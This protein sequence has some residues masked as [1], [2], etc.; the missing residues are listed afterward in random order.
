MR[1]VSAPE[2]AYLQSRQ[3]YLAHLLVHVTA[4]NLTSGLSESLGIWTGEQDRSFVI[5]GQTLAYLAAPGLPPPDPVVYET[6]L[7]VQRYRVK[8]PSLGPEALDLINGYD[9]TLAPVELHRALFNTATMALIAEPRRIFRGYIDGT[10]QVIPALGGE[11]SL[12]FALLSTS[13]ALTR[14]SPLKKSDAVQTQRSGDRL[15]QY[16]GVSGTVRSPWG[17]K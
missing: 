2:L 6:G 9:L 3:G 11:G 12:E 10:P 7:P 5:G 1:D 14:T 8:V 17:T 16:Q 15:R 13:F 4:R